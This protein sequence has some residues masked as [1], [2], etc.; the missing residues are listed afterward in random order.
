MQDHELVEL[1]DE[2]TLPSQDFID[3]ACRFAIVGL[4]LFVLWALAYVTA[5]GGDSNE[6]TT[7]IFRITILTAAVFFI[8]ATLWLILK[9]YARSV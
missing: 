6:V 9:R 7:L 8:C 3:N 4:F 2:E 5:T 1:N